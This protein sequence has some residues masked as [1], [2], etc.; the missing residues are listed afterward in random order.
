MVH[1]ISAHLVKDQFVGLI[2]TLQDV[3]NGKRV[4]PYFEAF[5]QPV[6]NIE[7]DDTEGDAGRRL[8]SVFVSSVFVDEISG[9]MAH[10]RNGSQILRNNVSS[11]V[12]VWVW[13]GLG[14]G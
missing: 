14:L 7:I 6:S 3:V 10:I 11:G 9:V 5:Y 8:N 1:Q 12:R 13:L 4:G 2:I